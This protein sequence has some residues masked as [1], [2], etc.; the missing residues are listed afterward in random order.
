MWKLGNK[1]KN[2][3]AK[4]D[5]STDLKSLPFK[6]KLKKCIKNSKKILGIHE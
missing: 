5:V 3:L 6:N 2:K 1:R 4:V